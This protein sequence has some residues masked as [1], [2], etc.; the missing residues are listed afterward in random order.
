MAAAARAGASAERVC[1]LAGDGLLSGPDGRRLA[2][3]TPSPSSVRRFAQEEERHRETSGTKPEPSSDLQ[4]IEKA[5]AELLAKAEQVAAGRIT[6]PK[7]VHRIQQA[8]TTMKN[9]RSMV[10]RA[11]PPTG[12]AVELEPERAE[13]GRRRDFIDELIAREDSGPVERRP[14]CGCQR[15]ASHFAG[16]FYCGARGCPH[17]DDAGMV[18]P[19]SPGN[20]TPQPTHTPKGPVDTSR[21]AAIL[22]EAEQADTQQNGA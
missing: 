20:E 14:G 21:V 12:P 16:Q 19:G 4:R 2:R 7:E 17:S 5:E 8:I 15:P 6:D 13:P 10:Q 9:A 1:E 22:A 18:S 11:Q 3:F